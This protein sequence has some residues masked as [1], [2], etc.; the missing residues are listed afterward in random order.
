MRLGDLGEKIEARGTLI[1]MPQG[2]GI[3]F[4]CLSPACCLN[5]LWP[6]LTQSIDF[7]ISYFCQPPAGKWWLQVPATETAHVTLS[8]WVFV[9]PFSIRRGLIAYLS[10]SFQSLTFYWFPIKFQISIMVMCC[11]RTRI[12]CEKCRVSWFGHCVYITEW[13]NLDGIAC[14]CRCASHT[15]AGLTALS[16]C[17]LQHHHK[18]IN[19]KLCYDIATGTLGNKNFSA[20]L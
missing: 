5:E 10:L 2:Q 18:H 9:F 7:P 19:I 14:Y 1:Q 8:P 3:F 12:H 6:T 20:P 15:V 13:K 16:V 11:V 4:L 17:L